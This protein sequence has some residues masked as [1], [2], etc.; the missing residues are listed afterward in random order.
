MAKALSEKQ[1]YALQWLH[2][3]QSWRTW[4]FGVPNTPSIS[5]LE[6]LVRKGLA[7]KKGGGGW[8][9]QYAVLSAGLAVRNG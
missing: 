1:L 8:A 2:H 4:G 6:S 5:T 9:A 7:A 3:D